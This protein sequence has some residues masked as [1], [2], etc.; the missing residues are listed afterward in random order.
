MLLGAKSPARVSPE[1]PTVRARFPAGR[2]WR[3]RTT[4]R[5]PWAVLQ[6]QLATLMN[7]DVHSFCLI[8]E[9]RR[10]QQQEEMPPGDLHVDTM[11]ICRAGADRIQLPR[12]RS[13]QQGHQLQQQRS[14]S[15]QEELNLPHRQAPRPD[16]RGR[17]RSRTP[18]RHHRGVRLG[19]P[20]QEDDNITIEY[21]T[22][23]GNFRLT[24]S[25]ADL[26]VTDWQEVR[27]NQIEAA[28]VGIY[29]EVFYCQPRVALAANRTCLRAM[30]RIQPWLDQGSELVV[31]PS[32]QMGAAT[33]SGFQ[34]S[35]FFPASEK[36]EQVAQLPHEDQR[37]LPDKSTASARSQLHV[38]LPHGWQAV[39]AAEMEPTQ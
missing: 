16:G 24:L 2:W 19:P 17:S 12:P 3:V 10:V 8:H 37:P 39:L 30:D 13:Q 34:V 9:G 35:P 5:Q 21:P 18:A 15:K 20:V 28:L 23:E 1:R 26:A 38:I 25:T 31:V 7:R 36:S 27:A 6:V 11:R 4:P 14:I 29:P 32:Q 22:S 33:F